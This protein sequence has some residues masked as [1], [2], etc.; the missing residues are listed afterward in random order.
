MRPYLF[1]I[2]AAAEE[3]EFF[4]YGHN[5][6]RLDESATVAVMIKSPENNEQVTLKAGDDVT[7]TPFDELRLSHDGT[8]DTAFTVYVGQNTKLGGARI[9]GS[10]Q[11][12]GGSDNKASP[13]LVREQNETTLGGV[14]IWYDAGLAV[15]N[16]A[17]YMLWNPAGSGVSI[18]INR[19][20]YCTVFGT[21]QPM[22][23]VPVSAA[24]GVISAVSP[25]NKNSLV[26][27]G[28]NKAELYLG[29]N[30]AVPAGSL[31]YAKTS[32]V[33][34]IPVNEYRQLPSQYAL[35][36]TNDEKNSPYVIAP[37]RGIVLG[38]NGLDISAVG[39][40]EWREVPV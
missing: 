32:E 26:S 28:S 13:P 40:A 38:K 36:F 12:T 22:V 17:T 4:G 7:L 29:N 15:V 1:K 35:G 23:I 3:A 5:Y 2:A 16:P 34:P 33:E 20:A 30:V 8:A 14:Y 10:V 27:D 37:G 24:Y 19:L 9:G 18:I 21:A 39:F 25:I 11:V 31:F 6:I